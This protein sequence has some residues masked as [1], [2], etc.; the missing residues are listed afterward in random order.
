MNT[1]TLIVDFLSS[2]LFPE[3]KTRDVMHVIS[4][5]TVAEIIIL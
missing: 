5:R 2:F 3:K 1:W 4:G